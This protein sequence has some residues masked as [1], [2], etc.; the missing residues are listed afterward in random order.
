MLNLLPQKGHRRGRRDPWQHVLYRRVYR[1]Q[2]A[3]RNSCGRFCRNTMARSDGCSQRTDCAENARSG[4]L[5]SSQNCS[6]RSGTAQAVRSDWKSTAFCVA[7][8]RAAR[9]ALLNSVRLSYRLGAGG[10]RHRT[11]NPAFMRCRQ[12]ADKNQAESL[13]LL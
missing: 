11:E 8:G 12:N 1:Q 7:H 3:P 13:S 2:F 4:E 6:F 10:C 5:P 9:A